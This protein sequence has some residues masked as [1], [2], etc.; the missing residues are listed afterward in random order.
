MKMMMGD[1][2]GKSEVGSQSVIANKMKQSHELG[3][4]LRFA[5]N[6]LRL[7]VN[8]DGRWRSEVGSQK[9]GVGSWNSLESDRF[10][11]RFLFTPTQRKHS[12]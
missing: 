5:R 3:G 8:E 10:S 7:L 6:D 2:S 1:G 4:L 12:N 9:S 11:L